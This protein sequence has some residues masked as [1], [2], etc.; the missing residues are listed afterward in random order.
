MSTEKDEAKEKEETAEE[1]TTE[2]KPAV[3]VKVEDLDKPLEKMTVASVGRSAYLPTTD[4]SSSST[5]PGTRS[6]SP[7][8]TPGRG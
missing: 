6:A 5:W 1:E 4:P 8:R 2:E 3:A 7:T